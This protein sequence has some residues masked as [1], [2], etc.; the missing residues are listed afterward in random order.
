MPRASWRLPLC[1]LLI[2]SSPLGSHPPVEPFLQWLPPR[3]PSPLL[4]PLSS[5]PPLPRKPVFLPCR[6][7]RPQQLAASLTHHCFQLPGTAQTGDLPQ[8]QTPSHN[9]MDVPSSH[10]I[11]SPNDPPSSPPFAPAQG[12]CSFHRESLSLPQWLSLLAVTQPVLATRRPRPQIRPF[13]IR[14]PLRPAPL[15]RLAPAPHPSPPQPPLP[16]L[17]LG[18][19]GA[20]GG[21]QSLETAW[22]PADDRSEASDN[23]R[24]TPLSPR[25][26]PARPAAVP[27]RGGCSKSQGGCS[28]R[29]IP[30][31]PTDGSIST[32]ARPPGTRIGPRSADGQAARPM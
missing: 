9:P 7:F 21:D 12:Q 30:A 15:P 23:G 10:P 27:L 31:T 24:L 13:C 25:R 2:T 22:S 4:S 32:R 17:V 26:V 3:P 1:P 14:R 6:P 29:R 16:Y 8:F 28:R 11:P 20:K 18:A 5:R 19:P